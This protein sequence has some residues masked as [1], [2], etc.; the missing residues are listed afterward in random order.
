MRA[1]RTL[2][3][4]VKEVALKGLL[5]HQSTVDVL[6][7]ELELPMILV[8]RW[9]EKL[10]VDSYDVAYVVWSVERVIYDQLVALVDLLL[11]L[12]SYK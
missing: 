10:E 5:S 2:L 3:Q 11:L 4:Q 12:C 6:K 1:H 8:P 7:V 9:I